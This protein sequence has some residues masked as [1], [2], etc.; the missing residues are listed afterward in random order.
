MKKVREFTT[1]DEDGNEL[2][3]EYRRPSQGI[4][5]KAD[6]VSRKKFSESV[7]EGIL[8]N[9]E[10]A[11]IL[12]DRGLW[13]D[14]DDE[15]DI[16]LQKEIRTLEEKLADES[17]SN[18]EGV[19]LV[20]EI[21]K[22]RLEL[23]SHRSTFTSISDAT[24]ESLAN[25]EKN[26]FLAASCV[27]DKKTGGKVYKSLEDFKQRLSE[28]AA[29]DSYREATVASLEDVLRQELP[30]DLTKERAEEKWLAERGLDEE[31]EAE[32]EKAKEEAPKKPKKKRGRPKK[33]TS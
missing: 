10:V 19:N 31:P 16:A 32:P 6:L 29:I 12:K 11:K 5:Q 22:L 15:K 30:S 20:D 8:L 2:V 4:L 21:K 7:R 28:P 27:F 33:K 1:V 26:M 3:Y 18:D 13:T 14:E 17:I 24:C 9:Q 25:E 23:R